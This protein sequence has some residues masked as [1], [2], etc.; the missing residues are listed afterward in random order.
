MYE[1][2]LDAPLVQFA[3]GVEVDNLTLS[4][5]FLKGDLIAQGSIKVHDHASANAAL[6]LSNKDIYIRLGVGK[7]TQISVR[8][9]SASV[10]VIIG[11]LDDSALNSHGTGWSF[12]IPG[13]VSFHSRQPHTTVYFD[14]DPDHGVIWLL[15]ASFR[16]PGKDEVTRLSPIAKLF[17]DPQ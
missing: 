7:I 14:K 17:K 1:D 2:M 15:V 9:E 5:D 10:E 6:E 3:Y 13:L 12:T 4:V 8:V 16:S 11:K